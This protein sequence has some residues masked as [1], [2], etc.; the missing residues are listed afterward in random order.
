MDYMIGEKRQISIKKV[1]DTYRVTIEELQSQKAVDL[2]ANCWIRLIQLIPHIA[3]CVECLANKQ[4]V[5]FRQHIGGAY[6]VSVSTGYYC[7]NIRQYYF[8]PI[9]GFKP[10]KIPGIALRVNEFNN[11][12][13]LIPSINKDFPE[14]ASTLPCTLQQDHKSLEGLLSCDEC[15]PFRGADTI[16]AYPYIF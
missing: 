14:L 2:N 6:F 15:Q 13:E 8:H 3:T 5:D 7:I 9:H 1:D 12:K 11:L 16:T 10:R 4:Y